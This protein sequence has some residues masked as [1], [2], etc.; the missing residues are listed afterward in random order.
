MP[1][2]NSE[3]RHV[4][5]LQKRRV[6]K[7][8]KERVRKGLVSATAGGDSSMKLPVD[9]PTAWAERQLQSAQRPFLEFCITQTRALDSVDSLSDLPTIME[10]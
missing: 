7:I 6:A 8:Q 2:L 1:F 10:V 9:V 3:V 5:E 4:D